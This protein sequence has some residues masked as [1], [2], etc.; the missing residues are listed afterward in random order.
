[1]FISEDILPAN[2]YVEVYLIFYLY[3]RKGWISPEFIITSE[4]FSLKHSSTNCKLELKTDETLIPLSKYKN[5][6]VYVALVSNS[7][8]SKNNTM[9]CTFSKEFFL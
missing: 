9:V 3:N 2:N 8:E 7:T 5:T 4:K 6:I 1:M